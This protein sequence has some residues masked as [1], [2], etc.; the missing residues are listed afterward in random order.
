MGGLSKKSFLVKGLSAD[1]QFPAVLI[2]SGNMLFKK[3][4]SAAEMPAAR[5]AADT[6]LA[7]TRTM[8][9]KVMGIGDLDLA[10][11]LP[12]LR[13]AHQPPG[14]SLLALNLVQAGTNA[15]LFTTASWQKVG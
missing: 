9:G 3:G 5:I 11:G 14:F 12:L 13:A 4:V 2:N 1:P 7:A 10:A 6:I 8:G 15:P